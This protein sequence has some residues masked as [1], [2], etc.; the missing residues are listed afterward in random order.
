MHPWL[1]RRHPCASTYT[2]H[3]SACQYGKHVLK[4]KS[5]QNKNQK[6][7]NEIWALERRVGTDPMPHS[8]SAQSPHNITKMRQNR[9]KPIVMR[10]S[11]LFYTFLLKVKKAAGA[12]ADFV[13]LD[14]DDEGGGDDVEVVPEEQVQQTNTQCIYCT[15]CIHCSHRIHFSESNV[16]NAYWVH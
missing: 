2:P 11:L 8:K 6:Y 15:H 13:V 10:S 14:S 16:Y 4:Q 5:A 7:T 1:I 3:A 9:R 12:S